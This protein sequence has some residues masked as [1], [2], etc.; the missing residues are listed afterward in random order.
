MS[1]NSN[2]VADKAP[3]Y[4]WVQLTPNGGTISYVIDPRAVHDNGK[5]VYRYALV[6]D[7]ALD[8]EA[9]ALALFNKWQ[10]DSGLGEFLN[11]NFGGWKL[12]VERIAQFATAI[13]EADARKCDEI[14]GKYSNQTDRTTL[15]GLSHKIATARECATAIRNVK[16][17]I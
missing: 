2:E 12:F 4:L 1:T 9:E 5:P 10:A 17:K 11:P 3:E 7:P 16:R 8:V 6:R 15:R 13:R 14:A